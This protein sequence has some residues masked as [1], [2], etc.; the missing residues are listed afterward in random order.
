MSIDPEE[1]AWER[2]HRAAWRSILGTAI[3]QLG[4]TDDITLEAMV[5][6]RSD[7]IRALR[8]LCAEFGDTEGDE[9]LHL[10]DVIEKHLG[11]HLGERES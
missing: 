7:A 2:G 11:R 9:R 3:G 5:A 6:E 10:A 1:A 8:S 4:H